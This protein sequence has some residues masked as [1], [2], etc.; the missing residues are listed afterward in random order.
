MPVT[1][2]GEPLSG[3]NSAGLIASKPQGAMVENVS[4]SPPDHVVLLLDIS[5]TE[6]A[7]DV[8]AAT[9]ALAE[10]V[11]QALPDSVSVR[12]A[13]FNDTFRWDTGW[14]KPSSLI[15][16]LAQ[17]LR[18]T[19]PRGGTALYDALLTASA[20]PQ[21]SRGYAIIVISDGGDDASRSTNKQSAEL[22]AQRGLSLLLLHVGSR[23]SDSYLDEFLKQAGVLDYRV[24]GVPDASQVPIIGARIWNLLRNQI[25][26]TVLLP[27]AD[28]VKLTLAPALRH[29]GGLRYF[30][31]PAACEVN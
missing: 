17:A 4:L 11:A 21:V 26:V 22:L 27:E 16:P 8:W 15:T 19:H 29:R 1:S 25:L 23:H 24:Q 3:I 13:S 30:S 7:K 2:H 5:G 10:G 9:S 28:K 14:R 12:V 31:P 20:D 6:S 18:G